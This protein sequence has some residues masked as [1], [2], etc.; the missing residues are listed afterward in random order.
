MKLIKHIMTL[1][2]KIVLSVLFFG[3]IG[4]TKAQVGIDTAIDFSLKDIYSDN[5]HLNEYLDNNKL[6]VIDFFTTTCG[7]CQTYAS[8]ISQAYEY[9]GCNEGNVVFLGINWGSNNI[10]VLEF[11]S[12]YGAN[13]PS[14]SGIQGGGNSVVEDYQTMSYPT[15]IVI[16]PDRLIANKYIWPPAFDSIVQ[17]VL[18]LGGLPAPCT[19]NV[20]DT[21]PTKNILKFL[22]TGE[23]VIDTRS[24]DSDNFQLQI[25]DITGEILL[26]Y[27]IKAHNYTVIRP[28]LKKGLY[29]AILTSRSKRLTSAKLFVP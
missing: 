6:V 11:D 4:I 19:V 7:P 23:L 29:I 17:E 20:D 9:F 14:V 21:E 2:S 26:T 3:N 10:E 8:Q 25:T 24:M 12:L 5:H 27:Q 13:Y 16:T 18:L 1:I 28:L 22:T 15:V